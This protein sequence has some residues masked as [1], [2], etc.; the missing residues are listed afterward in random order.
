[1]P[2][3]WIVPRPAAERVMKW[4]GN[5]LAEVEAWMEDWG[6]GATVVSNVNGLLTI[7]PWSDNIQTIDC[8][9]NCYIPAF[10]PWGV[11]DATGY[12]ETTFVPPF[13]F[14]VTGG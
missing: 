14:V 1:M 12:F 8:P 13:S 6:T 9:V 4:T 3:M 10:A 2:E 11:S 7:K 5:N